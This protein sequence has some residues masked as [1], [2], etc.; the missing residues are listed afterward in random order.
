MELL[1]IIVGIILLITLYFCFGMLVKFIWGWLPLMLGLIIGLLFGIFGGWTGAG[2]GF[3]LVVGA[4]FTT[5]AWQ[6]S[7][8][9]LS[10][11]ESIEK[12][13]YLND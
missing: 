4:V 8:L 6:G 10:V 9:F 7:N 2:V 3:L 12:K 11:E 13:F 5:D 1:A